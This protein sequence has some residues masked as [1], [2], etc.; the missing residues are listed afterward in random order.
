MKDWSSLEAPPFHNLKSTGAKGRSDPYDLAKRS[1][2]RSG[3]GAFSETCNVI[4][5][6][7]F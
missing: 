2:R 7:F 4:G 3:T 6:V 5:P 1:G